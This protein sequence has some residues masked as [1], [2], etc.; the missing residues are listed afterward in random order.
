MLTV[1]SVAERLGVSQALIY[2]LSADGRLPCYRIGLGRGAIRFTEQDVQA[3]LDSC[4]Q[5]GEHAKSA[6]P[7]LKHIRL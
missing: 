4:K 6:T 3:Y 1:R 7:R 2:Q 5:S